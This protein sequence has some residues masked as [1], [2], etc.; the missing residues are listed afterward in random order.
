MEDLPYCPNCRKIFARSSDVLRHLNNQLSSCVKWSND[1]N[2]LALSGDPLAEQFREKLRKALREETPL[3]PASRPPKPPPEPMNVDFDPYDNNP[4]D[5][6]DFDSDTSAQADETEEFPGAAQPQGQGQSFEDWVNGDRFAQERLTNPYYPFADALDWE[7]GSFLLRSNM[8]MKDIDDF[9]AL[10]IVRKFLRLSFS[11]AKELRARAELLP[12]G[13]PWMEKIIEF[14]GYPTKTPIILYYRDPL[15]CIE[16]LLRNPLIK[17][18]LKLTPTKKFRNGKRIYN[19]W[20]NS[21]GAWEMQ[22][23]LPQGSTLL[24]LIG[25]SD[26]TNISVMNGDR[27]AHPFLM[28]L[29]NIDMD[30]LMKASNHCFV[31]TALF[32][33]PKFLCHKDIR[34]LMERRLM[35]HC[36]D[37]V[38][39]PVK[40]AAAIGC[41]VSTSTGQLLNAYT[42]LVAYIVDTPEAADI[43]CV[44]GK[45]S[46]L[47]LASHKEFGD[48][49][50]HDER[51]GEHTWNQILKVTAAVDPWDIFK[52]QAESKKHRLSGVHLPFWRD[53]SLSLNPSRFLTPEPLHHWHK[54]FYD[55]DFQWCRNIL[56]D[57]ELDFRLSAIQPRVGFRHFKEGVTKIKQLGGR[58][59]R[60][61]ER[62]TVAVVADGIPREVLHAIRALIEFRFFGQA[63]EMDEET[64]GR[65]DDQL[66]EFHANKEHIITAGGREQD[67]F[68]IPKLEFMLSV[69]RSVRW[70]GVPMQYTAD[71]TEKAHSTEIKVPARTKTNH[72]DY[73][74]QIARHL[75]RAEKLR[76][77][78][79]IT[80]L[81]SSGGE[82]DLDSP[83]AEGENVPVINPDVPSFAGESVRQIRNLFQAVEG[84]RARYPS[85]ERRI[86]TTSSTAFC[87]NRKPDVSQIPIDDA[88]QLFQIPDLRPALGDYFSKVNY[89]RQS[90]DTPIIGGRRYCD[91]E[92]KLPFTHLEVWYSVRVQVMSPHRSNSHPLPAQTLQAQPPSAGDWKYGRYDTVLLCNDLGS[93]WPGGGFRDGTKGHTI[94]QIRLIMRPIWTKAQAPITTAYLMYAQRFDIVPQHGSPTGRELSTGTFILK[95]A[96]RSDGSR[97]GDIVEIG[98]IRIPAEVVAR[99][100]K[101]A[102]PRMTPY[103]SL[104]FSN[105]YRLNKYSSKELLWIFDS[106][107][108]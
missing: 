25:T 65:M 37:I 86:F 47:T 61:L 101:K 76:Q 55:H 104:E 85:A 36:L 75:D 32:P 71:V 95:R 21:N 29:A 22:E 83:D 11:S 82:L 30:F 84:H 68:Y 52:Y 2:R 99:F 6:V 26:K 98:N 66:A 105:E 43:A 35:H 18:H 48:A 97:M 78:D 46:H 23:T 15:Q 33:V 24:G 94:A 88:A 63:P 53:W 27:V 40:T 19:E 44:M 54:Q 81:K 20:I 8:T 10:Q 69:V 80:S 67:H 87:L 45:T 60:E 91:A 73:D 103:N 50:R 34:G 39:A 90:S 58:E 17:N 14:P 5:D 31:M 106:V 64:L 100:G 59:H 1:Y 108:L 79:L 13:P 3:K 38:C 7:I 57:E 70:V 9:L 92:C 4:D 62:C 77:F 28:S 72:K 42:P 56:T 41:R 49:R 12:G 16:Y 93:A 51:T 96:T 74:P 102:D 89:Q 107:S